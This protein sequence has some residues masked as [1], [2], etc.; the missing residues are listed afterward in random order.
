M[1]VE[2]VMFSIIR[3]EIYENAL[4]EFVKE[5]LSSEMLKELFE[6]SDKHDI[7]YIVASALSK[8]GLLNNNEKISILFKKC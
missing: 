6:L 5:E 8:I 4:D 1:C 7:A 3:N 2:P